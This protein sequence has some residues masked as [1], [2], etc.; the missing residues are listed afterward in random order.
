MIT[1]N[2]PNKIS[3]IQRGVKPYRNASDRLNKFYT[4][5]DQRSEIK[6]EEEE[7]EKEEEECS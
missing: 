5:V 7:E 4:Q 3:L 6:L 2:A 1:P